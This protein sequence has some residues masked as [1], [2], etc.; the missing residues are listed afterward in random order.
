MPNRRDRCSSDLKADVVRLYGPVAGDE[1]IRQ[2]AT[3]LGMRRCEP[4]S[5]SQTRN[6]WRYLGR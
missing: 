6:G 3:E 2:A 4:G 5:S 1:S